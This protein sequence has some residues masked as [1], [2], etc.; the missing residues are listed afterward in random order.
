MTFSFSLN[1][2]S[3]KQSCRVIDKEIQKKKSMTHSRLRDMPS[4]LWQ[5]QSFDL[6]CESVTH[7]LMGN[8]GDEGLCEMSFMFLE[9]VSREQEF[10]SLW[11]YCPNCTVELWVI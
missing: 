11:F 6:V 10:A 2:D 3:W 8:K 1:D 7:C 4:L 9:G 5:N